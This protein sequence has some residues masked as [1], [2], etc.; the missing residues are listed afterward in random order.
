MCCER[1]QLRLS[2]PHPQRA[3][4]PDL[5]VLESS[6]LIDSKR[7]RCCT[8]HRN[9]RAKRCLMLGPP[10]K[11]IARWSAVMPVGRDSETWGPQEQMRRRSHQ[12]MWTGSA[13]AAMTVSSWERA[14]EAPHLLVGRAAAVVQKFAVCG[15]NGVSDS[16]QR[17]ARPASTYLLTAGSITPDVEAGTSAV[18]GARCVCNHHIQAMREMI[19]PPSHVT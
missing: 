12:S 7:S 18:R 10:L 4:C 6:A 14:V 13:H 2:F 16:L 1:H 8:C 5:T 11:G 15:I 19:W 17:V 9:R 3:M